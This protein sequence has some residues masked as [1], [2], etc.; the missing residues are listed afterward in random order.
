VWKS[1]GCSGLVNKAVALVVRVIG[2]TS[3]PCSVLYR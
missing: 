1:L 3:L 2:I